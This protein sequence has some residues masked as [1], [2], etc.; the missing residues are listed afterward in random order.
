MIKPIKIKNKI[1]GEGFPCFLIAEMACAHQGDVEKAKELAR[2]AIKAKADA[3]QIQVFQKEFYMSPI[4]KEYDLIY[5]LELSLEEWKEVI[6]IIKGGDILFFAAGYDIESIK[7]LVKNDVDAFKIHS[8]D[9]SNPEVLKEVAQTRKPV[10]L[11]CGASTPEE[12]KKAIDFLNKFGCG[13]IILM[14]GYQAYPTKIEET[15][16]A[17]IKTLK[18][19]F[20]L[21]V[22][23]Y[24]HVNGESILAKIIPIMSMGYGA[25]VIE[26]HY[27]LNREEKGIDHESSLNPDEFIEFVKILRE[28]ESAIGT[29]SLRDFTEDELR[30]RALC[31]KSIVAREDILEGEKITRD[32]VMFVR[33]EPGIPPDK[34]NEIE[35]KIA[36]KK[37]LKFNNIKNND[38]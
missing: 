31:K 26:K 23:F 5:R 3:V 17:F 10:F 30:Y 9:T 11:S 15:N 29:S 21:N 12:I 2:I 18:T 16:L 37:I 19:M 13:D 22:G 24:D 33:N 28:C 34:F 1:I 35:G 38:F 14:H 36:K 20:G 6:K 32:K 27:I 7:F 8:S 25:Q 4:C